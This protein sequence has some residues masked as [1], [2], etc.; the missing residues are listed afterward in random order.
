[1]NL[2]KTTFLKLHKRMMCYKPEKINK[3]ERGKI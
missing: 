2:K 3:K 1:M